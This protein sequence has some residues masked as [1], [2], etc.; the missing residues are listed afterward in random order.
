M[1]TNPANKVKFG[2]KNVHYAPITS[3]EAGKVTYGTPVPIPGAV[4]LNLTAQGEMSKFYADNTAYYVSASNDGYQ[5][6]LEVALLP[7]SF[8]TDILKDTLDGTAKVLVESA[9]VET[10]PFALLFEFAGDKHNT[11][12]VLYN[13]TA[14]RPAVA[15]GTTTNTKDPKTTTLALTAAP[16]AD[17]K[18][19]GKST[20]DTPEDVVTNWYETVWQPAAVGGP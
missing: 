18:V 12:H 7:D 16:L 19:K 20:A 3:T 15:S 10:V 9:A 6:D 11:L 14:S 17:G 8:A 1:P 5:G 13:C 2:L 4:S